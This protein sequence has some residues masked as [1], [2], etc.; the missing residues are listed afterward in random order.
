[1]GFQVE[2]QLPISANGQRVTANSFEVDG[3]SVNSQAWG[4]RRC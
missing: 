2:N 4:G 1:M 3:V